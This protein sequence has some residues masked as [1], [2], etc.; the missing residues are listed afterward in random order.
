MESSE[1]SN[2]RPSDIVGILEAN[3]WEVEL[4][5]ALYKGVQALT[6]VVRNF[7]KVISNQVIPAFAALGKAMQK[8]V[9]DAFSGLDPKDLVKDGNE[10]DEDDE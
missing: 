8:V 4:K 10:I 5:R 9:E 6:P 7:T 2:K 3:L 1:S